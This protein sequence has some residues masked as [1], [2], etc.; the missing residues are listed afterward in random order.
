MH[1]SRT[2]QNIDIGLL[3]NYCRY[4]CEDPELSMRLQEGISCDLV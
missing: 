3:I 4:E 2:I 1:D